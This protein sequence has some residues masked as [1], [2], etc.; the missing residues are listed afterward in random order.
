MQWAL[1]ALAEVHTPLPPCSLVGVAP[2]GPQVCWD[3]RRNGP[4]ALWALSLHLRTFY[5]EVGGFHEGE[6]P[7]HR[8]VGCSDPRDTSPGKLP[9]GEASKLEAGA[10]RRTSVSPLFIGTLGST[11]V[12][13]SRA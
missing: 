2:C 1:R 6:R 13:D 5:H 8:A 10:A 12:L 9:G 4:R 7:C 11:M 3:S